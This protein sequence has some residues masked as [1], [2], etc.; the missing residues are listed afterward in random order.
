MPLLTRAACVGKTKEPGARLTPGP[1]WW[2][3]MDSRAAH[4][5]T[6]PRTI[7]PR[8][9]AGRAVLISPSQPQNKNPAGIR[10]DF[11]FV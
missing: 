7:F 10:R 4:L 2:E 3:R 6:V 5:K 11:H 9:W 8:L 1:A